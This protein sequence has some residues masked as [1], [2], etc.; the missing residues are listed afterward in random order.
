MFE[1]IRENIRMLRQWRLE[2]EQTND[3]SFIE[4]DW[5]VITHRIDLIMMFAFQTV[6]IVVTIWFAVW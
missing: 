4:Q 1:D 3:E 2:L 5:I 6:N